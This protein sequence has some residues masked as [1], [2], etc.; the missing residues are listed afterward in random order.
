MDNSAYYFGFDFGMRCIGVAVGHAQANPLSILKA[1]QGK[2]DWVMLDKLCKE[3]LVKGFVIGLAEGEQVPQHFQTATKSF[4]KELE[5]RYQ[6]P[7]YFVDEH[8]TTMEAKRLTVRQKGKNQR[9]DAI[10]A[11]IILQQFLDNKDHYA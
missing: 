7:C 9:H 10:A 3:W 6:L 1:Q 11:A 5:K 8:Y 4:A 2:P